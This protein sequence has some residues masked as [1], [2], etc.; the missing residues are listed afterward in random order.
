MYTTDKQTTTKCFLCIYLFYVVARCR[1]FHPFPLVF[2][3]IR[4]S[5]NN[6]V[7]FLVLSFVLLTFFFQIFSLI[8]HRLAH[9]SMGAT[10]TMLAAGRPM[11]LATKMCIVAVGEACEPW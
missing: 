10:T 1:F 6:R 4:P 9:E 7:E 11:S 3:S 8:V 2:I 5:K